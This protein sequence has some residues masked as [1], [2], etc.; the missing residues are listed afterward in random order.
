MTKVKRTVRDEDMNIL[1]FEAK[2]QP[3]TQELIRLLLTVKGAEVKRSSKG[4]TYVIM[5]K[6]NAPTTNHMK[7]SLAQ[8][9]TR[10]FSQHISAP[11]QPYTA[12]ML[13]K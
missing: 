11:M 7:R 1:C 13:K 4:I 12:I 3:N 5:P 8:R 9:G 6:S 10:P 2:N